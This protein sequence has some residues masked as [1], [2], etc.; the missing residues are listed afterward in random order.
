MWILVLSVLAV[1]VV[2]IVV[3]RR[4][5]ASSDRPWALAERVLD[6]ASVAWSIFVTAYLLLVPTYDAFTPEAFGGVAEQAL[7]GKRT[8]VEVNGSA[9]L[10]ALLIPIALTTLP[11]F[12]ASPTRRRRLRAIGTGLLMTFVVVGAL[13]VGLLYTPSALAMLIAAALSTAEPGRSEPAA[14][15]PPS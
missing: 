3:P 13:S 5:R 8:F 2:S 10:M 15:G 6:L 9:A 1:A 4:A 7:G 11:W 14:S 12:T